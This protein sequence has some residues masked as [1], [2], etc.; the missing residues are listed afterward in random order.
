MYLSDVILNAYP[1]VGYRFATLEE[2]FGVDDASE[3]GLE[4]EGGNSGR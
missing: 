2:I 1:Q 3:I 4:E